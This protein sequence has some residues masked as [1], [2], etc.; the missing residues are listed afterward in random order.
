M[1]KNGSFRRKRILSR[2]AAVRAPL[3]RGCSRMLLLHPREI[4][5]Y[6][7][8][9]IQNIT[10]RNFLFLKHLRKHRSVYRTFG[11]NYLLLRLTLLNSLPLRYNNSSRLLSKACSKPSNIHNC[12]KPVKRNMFLP[13]SHPTS[14]TAVISSE[15]R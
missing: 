8:Q 9:N 1:L 11:S 4:A 15:K 5:I 10:H 14:F 7:V 13:V 2:G 6:F 12:S 3:V